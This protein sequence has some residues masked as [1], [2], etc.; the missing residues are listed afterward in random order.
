MKS[1]AAIIA[2]YQISTSQQDIME[3]MIKSAADNVSILW[4]SFEGHR[5]IYPVSALDLDL[6]SHQVTLSFSP[7][8]TLLEPH[9]PVYVKLA[10]RETVFKGQLLKTMP[11]QILLHLPEEIHWRDFREKK[12]LQFRRGERHV[13]TR[14]YFAHLRADQLPSLKV[15][16][17]DIS[18]HGI[19]IYVSHD[20]ADFFQ[21]GKLIELTSLGENGLSRPLLGHVKWAK[22]TETRAE[23]EAGMDWKV[24]IKM[25]DP[26][27]AQELEAFHNGGMKI[28]R[29]TEALLDTDVLSPEFQEMLKAQVHSTLKKMKQRPALAK[30]LQ[31]LEILRGKDDYLGEHIQV[32]GVVCTFLARTLGWV[33]E[34]SLEKF[35]YASY[36]HDA[37]LFA[38]PRLAPLKDK[39]DL[40]RPQ[41]TTQEV[42]IFLKAPEEAARLVAQDPGAPPDVEM[43]LALQKELPDGTGFPRGYNQAKIPPMAALFII[44]HSLTD[45]IMAGPNWSMEEWYG[46]ARQKYRGGHF[47]KIMASLESVK[48]TLRRR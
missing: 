40:D 44:A 1:T 23:R 32:L 35:V 8:S 37:P 26:I 17:R 15:S 4:Q 20:N 12:R 5:T 6:K 22:R 14:P 36:M 45:A 9:V 39:V 10:F 18:E 38:H 48:I 25:L 47:T 28:R 42:E 19:G 33:S 7:T 29:A 11:G 43:M 3:V 13:V 31:Q 46:R 41:L 30:Y 21:S 24:G 27:P 34:A 16:L 2:S